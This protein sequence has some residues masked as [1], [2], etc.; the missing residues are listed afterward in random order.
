MGAEGY[1]GPAARSRFCGMTIQQALR[2]SPDPAARGDAVRRRV[3][4][5]VDRASE[6]LFGLI[7]VLTFTLSLGATDAGREEVSVV[8]IGALGCNIA[9]GLID[10][11]M[12]LIG[13][14]GERWIE[15]AWLGT[16]RG[17]QDPAH[18][19]VLVADQLPPVVL[20]ALTEADLER[21]RLH[22]AAL[23]ES[24]PRPTWQSE[25]MLAAGGVFLLVFLCVFPVVLPFMLFSDIGLALRVS[26][27][28]AILLLFLTGFAF[29]QHVGR[30]WQTGSMMV[31]IGIALV[32][33]AIALGG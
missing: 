1:C 7:M 15:A 10:A 18:G 27:I 29:G 3:L 22:L 23:A 32:A 17:E 6:I 16:I 28:V 30:P 11:I 26:N 4:D 9:W 8:L 2:T 25:D 19:R 31:V 13:V 33:I 12:Y 20:P 21:I 24:P 14:Q 5:P